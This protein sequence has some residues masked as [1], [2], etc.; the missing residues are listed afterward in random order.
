MAQKV[1][2]E[3]TIEDIKLTIHLKGIDLATHTL[4]THT[5]IRKFSEPHLREGM[6]SIEFVLTPN[7]CYQTVLVHSYSSIVLDVIK[8]VSERGLYIKV[9]TTEGMPSGTSA[10]VQEA[11]D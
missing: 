5:L 4:N 7:A 9:I 6:V 8:S 1:D 3:Q 10:I 11:C 2:Y